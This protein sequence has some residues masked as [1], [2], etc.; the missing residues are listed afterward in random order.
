M[1]TS[2]TDGVGKLGLFVFIINADYTIS[3]KVTNKFSENFPITLE[4]RKCI[5]SA[6]LMSDL[7][8]F[9]NMKED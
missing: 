8:L 5:F 3:V 4:S 7:E 2:G 1:A 6:L 9:S